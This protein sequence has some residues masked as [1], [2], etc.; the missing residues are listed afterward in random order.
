MAWGRGG[1]EW[2]LVVWVRSVLVP[3]PLCVYVCFW[4]RR[5]HVRTSDVSSFARGTRD[6]GR[7]CVCGAH[8]HAGGGGT[9]GQGRE[10]RRERERTARAGRRRSRYLGRERAADVL[11]LIIGVAWAR[12]SPARGL[13][14]CMR[15]RS[16]R[17]RTNYRILI[18]VREIYRTKS[19]RRSRA[20]RRRCSATRSPHRAPS[21]RAARSRCLSR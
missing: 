21:P 11:Y 7:E 12:L 16:R 6:G 5:R 20:A 19:R 3:P 13:V 10:V 14:R 18:F 2:L 4:G 8:G 9:E 17:V 15:A 1:G